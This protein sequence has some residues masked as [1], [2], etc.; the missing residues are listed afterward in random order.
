MK[1]VADGDD[2]AVVVV[3]SRGDGMA[4]TVW[5]RWCGGCDGCVVDVVMM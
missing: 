3:V 1:V 4:A 5:W 2:V